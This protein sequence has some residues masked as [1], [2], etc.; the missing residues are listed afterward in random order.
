MGLISGL[1]RLYF[2][3]QTCDS[4]A[5]LIWYHL[6]LENLQSDPRTEFSSWIGNNTILNNFDATQASEHRPHYN[7]RLVA[8]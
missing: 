2:L 3:L 1:A 6:W 4:L 8:P 7:L 5:Q